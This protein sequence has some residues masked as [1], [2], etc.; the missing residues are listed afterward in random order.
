MSDDRS[1]RVVELEAAHSALCKSFL[2]WQCRVRQMVV[3][4][5]GGRPAPGMVARLT[6]PGEALP[7]ARIITVIVNRK[8]E[9]VTAQFRHLVRK[10]HDPVQRVESAL[11]YLAAEHYQHAE[12]FSDLITAL[13]S[14]DSA[15][16]ERIAE[17]G[18]C[19][20]DFEQTTHAFRLPCR[21]RELTTD[22]AAFQATYWHNHLFN[23]RLPGAVRILGF[24]PD[25]PRAEQLKG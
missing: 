12:A 3:R 22:D 2:G 19:E 11:R 17:A 13:F 21:V 9:R 14:T 23:P 5:H 20:L 16:C 7:A 10:S 8:P 25:W 15:L 6:L 18:R 1:G 4:E 24:R